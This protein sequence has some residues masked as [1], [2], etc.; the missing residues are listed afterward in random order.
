MLALPRA[1]A[2]AAA[3]DKEMP[4]LKA[5]RGLGDQ[6]SECVYEFGFAEAT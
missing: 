3:V 2:S 6:L 1:T 5:G 4:Y